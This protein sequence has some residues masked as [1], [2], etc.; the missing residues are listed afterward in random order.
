MKKISTCEVCGNQDLD[1]VLDLGM[2]PL[3]DDLKKIGSEEKCEEYPIKIVYCKNCR[4]AHQ[5][6][7][8]DKEILFPEDYHYRA[9]FT[10]DVL[11]GMKNLVEEAEIYIGALDGKKVLDIGCNDGSLLN[12]FKEK[13]SV[14]FGIEPT[15]AGLEARENGHTIYHEYFTQTVSKSILSQYGA[16]DVITFTNVFA[17]IEN[18]NQLLDALRCLIGEHTIVIIENH[19]LGSILKRMQFDTFYHEH[20]RT[21]SMTSFLH[22]A[23]KLGCKIVKAEFPERYGGNIRVYLSKT[24]NT[25]D[26]IGKILD[27]ECGFV[28]TF[29]TM[30]EIVHIW[31]TQKTE[32]ITRLVQT[33]GKLRAKAFP[34][35]AAILLKLLSVDENQIMA[36]YEKPGSKKIGHYVPGTHI[37]ILNEEEFFS[38]LENN[39]PILNLAWHI[40]KEIRQ[41]LLKKGYDGPVIDIL[42]FKELKLQ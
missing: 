28:E 3:C 14:T 11:L 22:I 34:G 38:D 31:K 23:Q 26:E 37:K 15:A 39:G 41:Y 18:L 30:R 36:V 20:P 40:S 6:Y 25:S 29:S 5:K 35:R 32:Q 7:Q 19:Y 12:F 8:L 16:M 2:H 13:G 9:H 33:Y 42:D 4:T 17:H 21:Y 27:S 10:N 24:G 1:L